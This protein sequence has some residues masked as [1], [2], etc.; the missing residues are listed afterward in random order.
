MA[1]V[2]VFPG[3]GLAVGRH[4]RAR[5]PRQSGAVRATFD[6]ASAVL[7]YDLWKLVSAGPEAELNATERTQPAMLAAGVATWRCVARARRGRARGRLRPQPRGVHRAGVRRSAR[8]SRRRGAGALPRPGDAGGGA[9]GHRRHGGDPR[10]RGRA[11][12]A[13]CRE[14]AAGGARSW[15]SRPIS[16]RRARW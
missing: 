3:P 5:S 6:E 11:V 9:G 12:E 2:F 15:S 14:A 10:A 7:G 4:A 1:F 16:I 8:V 13:A